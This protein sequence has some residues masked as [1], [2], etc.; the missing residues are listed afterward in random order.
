MA[1]MTPDFHRV[2]I[3]YKNAVTTMTNF[4]DWRPNKIEGVSRRRSLPLHM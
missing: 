1:A 2:N 4:F 3:K